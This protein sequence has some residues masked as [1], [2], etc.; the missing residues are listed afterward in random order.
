MTA[1]S[2]AL[3]VDDSKSARYSLKKMLEKQ[4][5]E[6]SFAES[7]GAA[8]NILE[9]QKP[10]VIFMDHLMPGMDG[11]EA[12]KA[13]KSNP[14]TSTIP[15]VMC[16]SR[17]GAAYE[18]E[19][20]INGAIAILP[21]PAPEE[22]L[23]RILTELSE[24]IDIVTENKALETSSSDDDRIQQTLDQYFEQQRPALLSELKDLTKESLQQHIQAQTDR[25]GSTIDAQ[26]QQ[27]IGTL[28]EEHQNEQIQINEERFADVQ[29]QLQTSFETLIDEK[30][31]HS[32][33]H[34]LSQQDTDEEFISQMTTKV[35]GVLKNQ[36]TD[37]LKTALADR[38]TAL[39]QTLRKELEQ[40]FSK[41]VL[42]SQII[43]LTGVATGVAALIAALIL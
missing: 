11:F 34:E 23:I 43:G 5:I 20:K 36:L 2:Q 10:D 41:K 8:L 24:T 7:A 19:A 35:E 32:V 18:D 15:V 37:E 16:T 29:K 28:F 3:V 22:T 25:L 33:R 27:Q 30:V 12:T 17:E 31:K 21:K 38:E 4:G 1:I 42:Q 26:L 9:T 39:T 14:L 6:A 13:I 40:T